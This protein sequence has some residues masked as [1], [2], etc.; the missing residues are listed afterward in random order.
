MTE[1]LLQIMSLVSYGNAFLLKE[2]TSSNYYPNNSVFQYINEL[3][4]CDLKKTFFSANLKENVV[5]TDPIEWFKL[6]KKENCKKISLHYYSYIENN[7]KPAYHYAGFV[8]GAQV[9]HIETIFNNYSHFWAKK[10]ELKNKKDEIDMKK[11]TVSFCRK[12]EKYPS[13]NIHFDI[14]EM[15]KELDQSLSNIS[16]FAHKEN[17][18]DWENTFNQA[19]N[20]LS[21]PLPEKEYNR[22]DFI[23]F[24]NYS[25]QAQQ[26]LFATCKSWC[27][28]GMGWWNDNI[29][30]DQIK[31]EKITQQLYET[32]NKSIIAVINSNLRI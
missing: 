25:F 13:E 14:D 24:K 29:F 8:G 22:N 20:I 27:F 6:L 1:E 12:T 17:L 3:R 26:L 10:W 11:W 16:E 19:K 23:I 21:N 5:A 30:S 28:G 31:G 15:R 4:F 7:S 18:I 32:I 2:E 9:W